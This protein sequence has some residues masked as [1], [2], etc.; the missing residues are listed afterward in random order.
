MLRGSAPSHSVAA[1]FSSIPSKYPF[2]LLFLPIFVLGI[3]FL[4]ATGFLFFFV[5]ITI[6]TIT[7]STFVIVIISL[8]HHSSVVVAIT[9]TRCH[10]HRHLHPFR[11]H[12]HYH[13]HFNNPHRYH[14]LF[15]IFLSLF[16]C[17]LPPPP[18]LSFLASNHSGRK[19]RQYL[20]RPLCVI[21]I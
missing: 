2:F 7:T 13:Y 4:S 19:I 15:T 9:H 17:S 20:S 8:C 5:V 18:S 3:I 16:P 6:I 14:R 11:Y 10:C 12:Y 21:D 1:G